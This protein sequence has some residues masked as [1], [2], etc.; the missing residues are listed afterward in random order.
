M[1]SLFLCMIVACWNLLV[2]LISC[3]QLCKAGTI[4][5]KKA[6]GKILVCLLKK[7]VDGLSY[8]EG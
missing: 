8:A 4:D 3:S 7:E 5:P 2:L 1:C 6:K